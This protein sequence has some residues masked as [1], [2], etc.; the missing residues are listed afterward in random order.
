MRRRS[1]SRL[2][3][4][5]AVPPPAGAYGDDGDYIQ[6]FRR[7]SSGFSAAGLLL[8]PF[9]AKTAWVHFFTFCGALYALSDQGYLQISQT[10]ISTGGVP[11]LTAKAVEP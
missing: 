10:G 6:L 3:C 4:S 7:D 11:G 9:G 2:I 1:V 8:R 5:R